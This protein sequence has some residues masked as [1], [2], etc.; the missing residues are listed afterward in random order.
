MTAIHIN[1]WFRFHRYT[2]CRCEASQ[3]Y[4]WNSVLGYSQKRYSTSKPRQFL[5]SAKKIGGFT[6]LLYYECEYKYVYMYVVRC[7]YVCTYMHVIKFS[8]GTFVYYYMSSHQWRSDNFSLFRLL[9][10]TDWT[11]MKSEPF[12]DMDRGHGYGY[13]LLSWLHECLNVWILLDFLV[14]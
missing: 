11:W 14:L 2:Y 3:L 8:L 6:T 5:Q 1:N 12:I 7:M 4:K 9:I 13:W 10:S